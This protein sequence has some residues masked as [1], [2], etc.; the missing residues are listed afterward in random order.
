MKKVISIVFG[1]LCIEGYCQTYTVTNLKMNVLYADIDNLLSIVI[2]NTSCDSIFV[3]SDNG[4]LVLGD[5]CKFLSIP[6]K[7][8]RA[9][10]SV[11]KLFHKDTIFIGE[12]EFRVK[13]V[14]KP[15][16]LVCGMSGGRINKNLLCAQTRISASIESFDYDIRYKITKYSVKI[17]RNNKPIYTSD[18]VGASFNSMIKNEFEKLESNDQVIFY[19]VYAVRPNSKEELLDEI[20]FII[21][22]NNK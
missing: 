18:I 1:L 9:N 11:F 7:V 2:E 17:N 6:N 12:W 20:T 15:N 10:I 4:I 22:E 5:S 8:G 16:I 19:N 3:E 21:N 14:P 13:S